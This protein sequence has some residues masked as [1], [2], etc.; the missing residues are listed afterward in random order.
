MPEET[1]SEE[2]ST[3]DRRPWT[4]GGWRLLVAVDDQDLASLVGSL[5]QCL[6]GTGMAYVIVPA[7]TLANPHLDADLYVG[8]HVPSAP[9]RIRLFQT[10]SL[11]TYEQAPNGAIFRNGH[12]VW[13]EAP[14]E[15]GRPTS[16]LLGPLVQGED[17]ALL[18][19]SGPRLR[20][21]VA[22]PILMLHAQPRTKHGPTC[23]GW[24][25]AARQSIP[26]AARPS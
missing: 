12:Q 20:I 15:I 23:A 7:S 2:R 4:L 21:T 9:G 16:E 14:A 8:A 22:G 25:K 3:P 13:P 6:D 5:R 19:V 17:A 18:F 26:P 11:E 10:T 24:L 1:A